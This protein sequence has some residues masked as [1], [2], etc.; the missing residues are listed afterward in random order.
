ML[1]HDLGR[2]QRTGLRILVKEKAF[3]T[4]AVTAL[5]LGIGGITTMFS[6]V[7]GVMLRGFSFPNADRLASINFVDPGSA[8]FFGL[9]GSVSAMDFEE[10]RSQQKSFELLAAYLSGS[11]VSLTIDG[12]PK[13]Y[14]GAYVTEEF[15]R[16][17]GVVPIMGRDLTAADNAEGAAKVTARGAR[18]GRTT[19]FTFSSGNL[20]DSAHR[21]AYLSRA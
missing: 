6:V 11:T 21:Y 15:L 16:V 13:R 3:S 12:Q 7:N 4:L 8:T 19:A 1:V 2:D 20:K 9:N 18:L 14:I 10:L 17:L 5:A